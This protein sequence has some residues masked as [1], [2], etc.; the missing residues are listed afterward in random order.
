[1]YTKN[2]SQ[3]GVLRNHKIVPSVEDV[4]SWK[5]FQSYYTCK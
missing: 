5:K 3:I 2:L 4:Y 1:M